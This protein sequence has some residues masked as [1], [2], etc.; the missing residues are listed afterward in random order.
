MSPRQNSRLSIL[1]L[2][3]G[4]GMSAAAAVASAQPAAASSPAGMK[5]GSAAAS[6][7]AADKSWA[8]KAAVGGMAEVELGKLA[9]Q[10]ASNDQVKQF[11]SHMPK[12][13]RRPT[14]S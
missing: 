11:G 9:Q 4:F 6:V 14:T 7:P 5:V 10:K 2:A 12:T 13:T 8:Q 3:L 1:S